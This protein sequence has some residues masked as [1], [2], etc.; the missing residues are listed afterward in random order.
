MNRFILSPVLC[1][2]MALTAQAYAFSGADRVRRNAS[3]PVEVSAP[4]VA[5]PSAADPST[6]APFLLM[7]A[8]PEGIGLND[9]RP[10]TPVPGNPG[11]N[12]GAQR[13]YVFEHAFRLLGAWIA[14]ELPIRTRVYFGSGIC[15]DTRHKGYALT[16]VGF[17]TS[18]PPPG[19]EPGRLYPSSLFEA[20]TGEEL[21]EYA[22]DVVLEFN[23]APDNGHCDVE[24]WYYG[25]DPDVAPP[26]GTVA[27]LPAVLH[28]IVH[29][30]G[31][32]SLAC[33]A[34]AG[35]WDAAY[36][37]F[38]IM[39][40]PAI[41]DTR[42]VDATVPASFHTLPTLQRQ[43]A[44]AQGPVFFEGAASLA[45]LGALGLDPAV[46]QVSPAANYADAMS[47]LVN[48][49]RLLMGARPPNTVSGALDIAPAMLHDLGWPKPAA[50]PPWMLAPNPPPPRVDGI[51][52]DSF[53]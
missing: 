1:A 4:V 14:T 24:R 27:L 5:R 15:N 8:D 16:Q 7:V 33:T 37:D 26:P 35:C 19:V 28:E 3:A 34:P 9:L 47:H 48:D 2:G 30:L 11:V 18:P 51:F 29:A 52:I 44:I 22:S 46:L 6:T 12:R 21:N 49:A 42:L 40:E 20:I 43:R 50:L 17:F 10:A 23:A 41:Y 36:G 38:T 25:L 45:A 53:E 31:V 39:A 32:Q 13:R